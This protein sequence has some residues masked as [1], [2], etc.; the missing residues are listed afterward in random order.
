MFF[1]SAG[2]KRAEE[3]RAE[4]FRISNVFLLIIDRSLFRLNDGFLSG[5]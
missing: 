5:D 2:K 4:E 3:L 1:E